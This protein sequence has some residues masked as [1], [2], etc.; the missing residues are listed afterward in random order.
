MRFP[1]I[2]QGVTMPRRRRD[3]KSRPDGPLTAHELVWWDSATADDLAAEHGSID[4]ARDVYAIREPMMRT[5]PGTRLGAFWILCA[6]ELANPPDPGP[7]PTSADWDDDQDFARARARWMLANPEH[8]LDSAD[9]TA[10]CR[11]LDA[12]GSP[13]VAG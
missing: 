12:V 1:G 8:L 2:P 6:P 10:W 3:D 4:A 13:P 7:F 11:H 5:N 9:R